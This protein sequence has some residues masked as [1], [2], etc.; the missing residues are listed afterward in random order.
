MNTAWQKRWF[1]LKEQPTVLTYHKDAKS[2]ALGT[3]PLG[4][5]ILGLD[6]T[7]ENGLLLLPRGKEVTRT[8]H[9]EA[10]TKELQHLWIETFTEVGVPIRRPNTD[11]SAYAIKQGLLKKLGGVNKNWKVRW[12]LIRRGVMFYF[13]NREAAEA[14]KPLGAIPLFKTTTADCPSDEFGRANTFKLFH[15]QRRTYYFQADRDM[16]RK[17]WQH[18]LELARAEP[19]NLGDFGRMT[20]WLEESVGKDQWRKLWF[21]LEQ[22]VIYNAKAPTDFIINHAFDLDGFTMNFVKEPT[23]GKFPITFRHPQQGS[24]V[25]YAPSVDEQRA[26][27]KQINLSI[28]ATEALRTEKGHIGDVRA[29]W[30][31]AREKDTHDISQSQINPLTDMLAA[32]NLQADTSSSSAHHDATAFPLPSAAHSHRPPPPPQPQPQPQPLSSS[33]APVDDDDAD[34]VF[35][36]DDYAH[37]APELTP[38]LAKP[39]S[40]DHHGKGDDDDDDDDDADSDF[41]FDSD[42]LDLA[43]EFEDSDSDD[44]P[45]VGEV[46]APAFSSISSSTLSSASSPSSVSGS[47]APPSLPREPVATLAASPE[48]Q[49]PARPARSVPQLPPRPPRAQIV[50]PEALRNELNQALRQGAAGAAGSVPD[51]PADGDLSKELSSSSSTLSDAPASPGVRLRMDETGKR[52]T[53]RSTDK[54]ETINRMYEEATVKTGVLLKLGEKSSAWQKRV[55]VLKPNYLAYFKTPDDMQPTGVIHLK[56]STVGSSSR[57]ENCFCI[58]KPGRTYFICS[59]NAAEKDEWMQAIQHC[60]ELCLEIERLEEEKAHEALQARDDSG[61]A[62]SSST[63]SHILRRGYMSKRGGNRKNWSIRFFT[64][65]AGSLSYAKNEAAKPLGI[66]S[67]ANAIIQDSDRKPYSFTIATPARTYFIDAKSYLEKE[68]W[69]AALRKASI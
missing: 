30:E 46:I 15:P 44:D 24:Y 20:G 25:V 67:L 43:D 27:L 13:E 29:D 31:I 8:Y 63:P 5:Y 54:V 35:C 33:S 21:I 38:E 9:L 58:N 28:K 22:N 19:P 1:I 42:D 32:A 69:I 45:A 6:G 55:F 4:D 2:K 64:L 11:E 14:W 51:V 23:H 59:S 10:P 34:P 48:P 66:I 53:G 26:W 40:G 18:A 47:P 16:D 57:R 65:Q 7:R 39:L 61:P 68:E 36:P 50:V 17:L 56:R 41:D 52:T 3:I 49:L 60:V 37:L 12:C 62:T